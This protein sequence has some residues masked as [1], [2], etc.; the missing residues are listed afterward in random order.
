MVK[1][2][3]QDY[4]LFD[5]WQINN[6]TDRN[7]Y[8]DVIVSVGMFEHVNRNNYKEFMN[9]VNKLLKPGGIFLLHTIGSVKS[10]VTP[11]AWISNIYFQ[12]VVYLH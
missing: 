1:F 11:D 8:Y 7:G 12:I 3:L 10:N 4:R 5:P 9:I 6:D 2:Y